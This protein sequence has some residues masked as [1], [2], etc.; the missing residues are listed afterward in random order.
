MKHF[1]YTGRDATGKLVNGTCDAEDR[2]AVLRDLTARGF[3]PVSVK[4]APRPG[5]LLRAPLPWAKIAVVGVCVLLA[6]GGAW[7]LAHS[8][9]GGRPGGPSLPDG[10][11]AVP[12]RPAGPAVPVMPVKRAGATM[13]AGTAEP[14]GTA[15][16][17]ASPTPV[18]P[19]VPAV[20]VVPAV[21]ASPADRSRENVFTVPRVTNANERVFNRSVEVYM[22]QY[23][24]PGRPM[25]PPPPGLISNLEGQVAEA[26]SAP[27]MVADDEPEKTYLLKAA[28]AAMKEELREVLKDG[29]SAK[30]YFQ[31]LHDRQM[32]E[33]DLYTGARDAVVGLVKEGNVKE[34]KQA[35]DELNAHMK[36]QGLPPVTVPPPYRKALG[37]QPGRITQEQKEKQ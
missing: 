33:E 12:H 9:R 35:L 30:E 28:V 14:T 20:P 11:A 32:R 19:A 13:T 24:T 18:V 10:E 22:A 15:A 2:T 17:P 21:P 31:N 29:G 3:V 26:L 34:A 6:A 25:P 27:I 5:A 23:L 37:I 16:L 1:A 36:S 7:L 8:R 4:E